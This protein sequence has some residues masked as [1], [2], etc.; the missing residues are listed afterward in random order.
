MPVEIF[1]ISDKTLD[2]MQ[3]LLKHIATF[4]SFIHVETENL[5]AMGLVVQTLFKKMVD[6]ANSWQRL[7]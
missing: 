5:S 1:V 6:D 3:D 2:V 7:L 4:A